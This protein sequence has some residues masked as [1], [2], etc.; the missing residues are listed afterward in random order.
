MNR[1]S[2]KLS[3]VSINVSQIFEITSPTGVLQQSGMGH[4][5]IQ[6]ME[7]WLE[8]EAQISQKRGLKMP[9]ILLKNIFMRASKA[10]M[11]IKAGDLSNHITSF[12]G[13]MRDDYSN[14]LA[15][16]MRGTFFDVT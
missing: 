16:E 15:H 11:I 9:S 10:N 12:I 5:L 6:D 7:I 8:L 14:F 4:S 3:N 2:L 1:F 13:V